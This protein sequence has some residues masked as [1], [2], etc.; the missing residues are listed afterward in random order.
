MPRPPQLLPR[1]AHAN[2]Q[3]MRSA[4]IDCVNDDLIL[5]RVEIPMMRAD[6]LQTGVSLA[7]PLRGARHHVGCRAKEVQP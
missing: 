1:H 2:Q 3:Q 5:G 6:Q 7:Q 4:A